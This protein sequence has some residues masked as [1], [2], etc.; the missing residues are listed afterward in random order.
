[1]NFNQDELKHYGVIGMKWGIHRSSKSMIKDGTLAGTVLAI[2]V[3]VAVASTN[4]A[5]GASLIAGRVS[6]TAYDVG[7][8]YAEM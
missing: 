2:S 4:P 7:K 8:R 1:M 6:S 3:A 5:L